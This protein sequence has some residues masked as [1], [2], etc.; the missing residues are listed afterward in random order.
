MKTKRFKLTVEDSKILTLFWNSITESERV[1]ILGGFTA[2]VWVMIKLK[3]PII[4]DGDKLFKWLALLLKT[5]KEINIGWIA[6][7]RY[8]FKTKYGIEIDDSLLPTQKYIEDT[9]NCN[10][11]LIYNQIV[12]GGKLLFG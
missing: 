9:I 1:N 11:D 6:L 12:N 5:E 2:I 7:T 3:K 8:Y 10:N 4:P